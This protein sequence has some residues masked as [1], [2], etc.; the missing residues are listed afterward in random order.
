MFTIAKRS[1]S[2]DHVADGAARVEVTLFS[3]IVQEAGVH[4][5]SEKIQDELGKH[6]QL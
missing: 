3:K 1:R 5:N 4:L 6:L 2:D